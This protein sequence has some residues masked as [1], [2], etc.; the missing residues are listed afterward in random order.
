MNGKRRKSPTKVIVNDGERYQSK[1]WS[2]LLGEERL[3]GMI[4]PLTCFVT[5]FLGCGMNPLKNRRAFIFFLLFIAL[6]IAYGHFQSRG[7]S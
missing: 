1:N 3:S 6:P 5:S 7:R 4:I 2:A